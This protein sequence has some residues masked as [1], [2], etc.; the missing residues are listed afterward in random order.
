[1]LSRK[2]TQFRIWLVTL[3]LFHLLAL[4]L[5]AS[6]VMAGRTEPGCEELNNPSANVA[7]ITAATPDQEVKIPKE[8]VDKAVFIANWRDKFEDATIVENLVWD[9]FIYHFKKMSPEVDTAYLLKFQEDYRETIQLYSEHFQYADQR[10]LIVHTMFEKALDR[11]EMAAAVPFAW[12]QLMTFAS[13]DHLEVD[14]KIGQSAQRF[15]LSGHLLMRG[16]EILAK[17]YDCA[18]QIP[19]VAQAFDRFHKEGLG[20]SIGDSAAEILEN[21][22]GLPILDEIRNRLGE[23]GTITL[24]L[25]ELKELSKTEFAKLNASIDDMQKTLVEIDAKQDV[26]VD[27]IKNQQEKEKMEALARQKAAEHQLKLHAIA[28]SISI[29]TTLAN[30]IDPEFAKEFNVVANSSLQVG[31]AINGWLNAVSGLNGLDKVTSLST[32]VMTGNV[33]GAVMN[34]VALFGETQPTPEEIIL[35]EI[36]KLRE[37]VDQLRL[38]MHDRFDRVDEELSVIYS[39]MHDRF[40]QIDIQL[41]KINGNILELQESLLTLDL[42]LSRIERNNFEFLNVLGRRPLMD[43]I[44]GGLSYAERTGSPMPFQP[45]FVEFE[46]VLQGWGTI[47]AFDALNAGPTQ[48]DYSDGQL[49][50]ELNTYP[51]DSNINY[52]NGWLIAHGLSPIANKHLASPR[53]WLFA[54]RA[55]TQLTLE[56][57]EHMREIDPQRHAALDEVGIELEKAMNNIS[58]QQTTDGPLGNSLLFT[59]VITLYQGKL[60]MLDSS[61]QSLENAFVNEVQ[62]LR[63]QRSEPFDLYGGVDQAITYVAPELTTMTCGSAGTYGSYPVPST[64]KSLIPDFARYNLADYL[65]LG[66]LTTCVHHEPVNEVQVCNNEPEPPYAEVCIP[67]VAN[68][69]VLT[70]YFDNVSIMSQSITSPGMSTYPDWSLYYSQLTPSWTEGVNYK[71][72]FEAMTLLDTPSPELAAQRIE[73]LNATTNKVEAALSD[74]QRELYARILNELSIGSLQ[75]QANEVAGSKALLESFVTLGLSRAVGNDDFLHAMLFG[76]QQL[77]DNNQIMESYAISVS[78]PI[79]GANLLVNPRLLIGKVADERRAALAEMIDQY[80]DAISAKT[81]V[82]AAGYLTNTR[83]VLDLTMRIARVDAP[84][85]PGTPVPPGIPS[86]NA[87]NI[88]L[89]LIER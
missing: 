63:L 11:P 51:M 53:D 52:L 8:Q 62:A 1:M 19:E 38:E 3:I 75:S 58:T 31:M 47:H 72:Q 24:S 78:Q 10:D 35:E 76:N 42:K 83:R 56:W 55:Y 80:L 15:D 73:L 57:P 6:P 28:S 32:I 23:D 21:N 18:Q 49:L 54:S 14:Q 61:I 37:Q 69:A 41:G 85:S 67:F 88:H 9:M 26:I 46:N 59:T 29:I 71:A 40:S 70:V 27:Y 22:Q 5:P 45:T 60:G 16:S 12:K 89:P 34:I 79:T 2:F 74:Y 84:L 68:K 77:V 39:T 86:A 87:E 30:Q 25:N 64:L 17:V 66:K 13:P 48:R 81:H 7:A 20:A 82:E 65:Q 4:L 44:N 36:G 33:L 50:A 43:A